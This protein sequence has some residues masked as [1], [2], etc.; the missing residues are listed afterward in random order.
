MADTFAFEGHECLGNIIGQALE[1]AGWTHVDNVVDAD[2][3]L[4][5]FTSGAAVEDAYFETDGLIRR[6]HPNTLLIDMSPAT[7]SFARELAAVATVNELRFAE[8]PLVVRDPSAVRPLAPE[9]LKCLMAGDN[10]EILREAGEVVGIIVDDV[11]VAGVAGRAQLARAVCTSQV[12]SQVLAAVESVSLYNAFSEPEN[13]IA[14]LDGFGIVSSMLAAIGEKRFDGDYTVE[15][16]MNEVVTAIASAED[17]DLILPQLETAMHLL[18]LLAV[19]GGADKAP[20]ALALLYREEQES[21]AV[22]LDWTRAEGL[23]EAGGHDHGHAH[24]H[25]Y[26]DGYDDGA[27]FYE[28]DDSFGLAGGFGGYSAN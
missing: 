7:P 16:M 14:V 24:D 2:V 21:A 13:T 10:D 28:D 26:G 27:E 15:M 5:Y 4:T 20:A 3:V 1:G 9:N 12:A 25:G 11:A 8:A 17:A 6:A 18:E 19:I 23:F 22:G